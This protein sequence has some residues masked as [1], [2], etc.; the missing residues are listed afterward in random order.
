LLKE[1]RKT[2]TPAAKI[3]RLVRSRRRSSTGVP[4]ESGEVWISAQGKG[5]LSKIKK[6][7]KQP[8]VDVS[9]GHE[10]AKTILRSWEW[11]NIVN[12]AQYA[13]AGHKAELTTI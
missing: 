9:G 2:R 8:S 4:G 5:T 6:N 11:G 3:I 12:A 10:K 7:R 13:S 1:T